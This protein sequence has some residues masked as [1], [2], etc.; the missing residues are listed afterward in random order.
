M[1]I[2]LII[3]VGLLSGCTT[4]SIGKPWPLQQ[5]AYLFET[6][7]ELLQIEKNKHSMMEITDI[8]EANYN[9]WHLCKLKTDAWIKWYNTHWKKDK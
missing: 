9:N 7:P 2:L 8:V 3:I 5:D 1:K 6:C 4:V